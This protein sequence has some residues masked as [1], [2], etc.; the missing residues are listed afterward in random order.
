ML[1]Q[2]SSCFAVT[3][4]WLSFT[5][6]FDIEDSDVARR[7]LVLPRENKEISFALRNDNRPASILS[8]NKYS[9]RG[10]LDIKRSGPRLG[11]QSDAQAHETAEHSTRQF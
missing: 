7:L 1:Q 8:T 4:K 5:C 10:E 11:G 9:L 6:T 3:P 2:N